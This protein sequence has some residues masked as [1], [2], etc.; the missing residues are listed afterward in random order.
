LRKLLR[1][2]GDFDVILLKVIDGEKSESQVRF[3][4]RVT[5]G[6][7]V[8]QLG[9]YFFIL[10]FF[11]GFDNTSLEFQQIRFRR[12]IFQPV[13]CENIGILATQ[14]L[15]CEDFIPSRFVLISVLVSYVFGS[16]FMC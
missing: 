14:V 15:L 8:D 7:Q 4:T 1:V 16:C 9:M 10:G 12:L 11:R 5:I 2:F 6:Q 3:S 13:R